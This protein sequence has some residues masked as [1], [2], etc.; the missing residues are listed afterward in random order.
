VG[1]HDG[2]DG[3]LHGLQL[4]ELLVV[5]GEPLEGRGELLLQR[6]DQLDE[7]DRVR[8]EVLDERLL[9][10]DGGRV[11]LEDLREVRSDRPRHV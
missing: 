3:V 10:G 1:G 9:L 4:G 8:A 7:R 6:V 11:G 2:V 5:E